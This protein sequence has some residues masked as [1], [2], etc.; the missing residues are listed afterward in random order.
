MGEART[1]HSFSQEMLEEAAFTLIGFAPQYRF[2]KGRRESAM[3]YAKLH[4]NGSLLRSATTPS[5]IPEA[6]PLARFVLVGMN[7]TEECVMVEV[8]VLADSTR[9]AVRTA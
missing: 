7:L 3:L 6:V 9:Y 4:G 5:I 2:A 8:G 1:A